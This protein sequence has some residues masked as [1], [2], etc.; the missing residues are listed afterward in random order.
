MS[1]MQKNQDFAD[2]CDR[3]IEMLRNLGTSI[4]LS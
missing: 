1:E 3:V 2:A 4:T